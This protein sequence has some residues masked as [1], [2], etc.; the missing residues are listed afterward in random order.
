[1]FRRSTGWRKAGFE[2]LAWGTKALFTIGAGWP[3]TL[4]AASTFTNTDPSKVS[5]SWFQSLSGKQ[6]FLAANNAGHTLLIGTAFGIKYLGI[7]VTELKKETVLFYRERRNYK[8]FLTAVSLALLSGITGGGIASKP[9]DGFLKIF[10]FIMGFGFIGA[11]SFLSISRIIKRYSDQDTLTR[12]KIIDVLKQLDL[13]SYREDVNRLM[14]GLQRET[15]PAT[16]KQEF[17]SESLK[18]FFTKLAELNTQ[19]KSQQR[20]L[21]KDPTLLTKVGAVVDTLSGVTIA[22]LICPVYIQSGYMGVGVITNEAF[23]TKLYLEAQ[24]A[25]SILAAM[26]RTFFIM[27][28]MMDTRETLVNVINES[29]DKT[30]WGLAVLTVK[31]LLYLYS[32]VSN[33]TYAYSVGRVVA[34]VS[35]SILSLTPDSALNQSLPGAAFAGIF[36][37]GISGLA[38]SMFPAAEINFEHP[39]ILDLIKS[40]PNM[41]PNDIDALRVLSIF[42]KRAETPVIA[43]DI[44]MQRMAAENSVR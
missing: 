38:S 35:N 26:P 33:S 16:G 32:N 1:M 5:P 25:F 24:V 4:F 42:S 22:V 43:P 7:A 3:N 17:T 12:K 2:S 34:N 28:G 37:L 9:Y 19:L 44:E 40:I 41:T 27:L 13:D 6:Q 18:I 36:C 11:L 29:K 21:C 30:P 20:N 31:A 23:F 10:E 39:E 15:N 14:E 8:R